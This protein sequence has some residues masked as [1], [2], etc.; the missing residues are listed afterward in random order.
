M[1]SRFTDLAVDC[2]D[3]RRLA[4]FWCAVLGYEIQEDDGGV[5]TI[6][7][8]APHG[9]AAPT[10]TFAHVPE[11]KT[12]KNRL[13]VDLTPTDADQAHEVR[14]LLDLGARP[15]DVGQGDASWV[16]LA[17]PEGNEFCVLGGRRDAP[18]AP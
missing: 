11:P 5:V 18:T 8:P 9:G 4:R 7:A 6:G 3:P 13:H 16:V 14:R 2:A 15:V 1:T 12:L 17:D 10:L